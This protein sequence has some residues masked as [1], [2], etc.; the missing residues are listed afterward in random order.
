MEMNDSSN[1]KNIIIIIS[2]ILII[3]LP[4]LF[5]LFSSYDVLVKDKNSRHYV[6]KAVYITGNMLFCIKDKKTFKNKNYALKNKKHDFTPSIVSMEKIV[7][8]ELIHEPEDQ[9]DKGDIPSRFLGKYKINAENHI[10]YLYLSYKNNKLRGTV[11]FPKWARGVYEPL[12]NI[13]I[14]KRR[15]TFTRSAT[16]H[17]EMERI[18][19]NNQIIQEY[20]GYFS[21]SGKSIKGTYAIPNGNRNWK[22]YKIK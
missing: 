2:A 11:I 4:F 1:K 14:K 3:I 12:K 9:E 16:T 13:K 8:L 22:A 15:I 6:A 19:L 10:G 7:Y 21:A 5:S 20:K 17:K 18:G